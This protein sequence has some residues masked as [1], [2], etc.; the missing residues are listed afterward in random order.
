MKINEIYLDLDDVLN[1]LSMY[2]LHSVGLNVDYTSYDEYPTEF[3]YDILGAAKYLASGEWQPDLGTFWDMLPQKVWRECPKSELCDWLID[4]SVSLVGEENVYIASSPTKDPDCLA[5]KLEWI[6]ENLPTF[7]H[8]QYFI[9][10]RKAQLAR[11]GALLIDDSDS[12]VLDWR[13]RDGSAITTPRPWNTYHAMTNTAQEHIHNELE[14]V[15]EKDI[16]APK[17]LN[18]PLTLP[19]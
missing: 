14:L 18:D 17:I 13:M 11:P 4:I 6:H 8:R 12:N 5:G 3:R 19:V 16:D 2:I 9:T 15:F 7:L 1:R 10:P